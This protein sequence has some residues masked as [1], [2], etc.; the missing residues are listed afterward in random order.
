MPGPKPTVPRKGGR[1]RR[2]LVVF[3]PL[4]G[5]VPAHVL[6]LAARLRA[7][8][9]EAEVA[10]P[11]GSPWLA[12]LS[13]AGLS[14]YDLP[15]ARPPGPGAL[16]AARA[17]R[18][19]DRSRGYAI[20]HAHSSVA[21]AVTRLALSD[22]G[23]FVYTPHCFSF[24]ARFGPIQRQFYRAVEQALLPRTAAV[25]AASAWERDQAARFLHGAGGRT[26]VVRNGVSVTSGAKLDSELAAFK[27][28]GRL[29]GFIGR[30]V[31]QKNPLTLVRAAALLHRRGALQGRVALVGNG[32]LR[33]EVDK[34]IEHLGVGDAVRV[35]R[36]NGSVESYLRAFDLMVVPS[37]WDS[38]PISVLEAMACGL[39]VI[40][41]R[42]GGITEAVLD[43]VNGRLVEPG[44]SA[45][46][47]A[48]LAELLADPDRLTD[49][50][51]A[52][53]RIAE[54]RFAVDRMVRQTAEVYE[55]VVDR[56]GGRPS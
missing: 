12:R 33:G 3:E 15:F 30:L 16:R 20:I 6:E 8:G 54:E 32:E 13:D 26:R 44:D 45:E 34:E 36:F 40:A 51:R 53:R 56:L 4:E 22:R 46:L 17:L 21:G 50:G 39:P 7:H 5:G 14:V 1:N 37:L 9:W 10:G 49:L 18:A 29:T 47:A 23:R 27:G 2:V 41:S 48:A 31:G 55:E 52:G 42:V 28:A 19:L 43:G 11:A 35:F 24:L 25:I 38:M